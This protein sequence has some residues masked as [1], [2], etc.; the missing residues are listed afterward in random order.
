MVEHRIGDGRVD[1][2]DADFA[3]TLDTER[4]HLLVAFRQHDGLHLADVGIHRDVLFRDVVVDVA[5][6]VRIDFRLLQQRGAES[7]RSCRQHT[8]YGP[9]TD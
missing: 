6:E 1:P 7:P 2:D 5:R 4:V 8:G 3:D 9:S